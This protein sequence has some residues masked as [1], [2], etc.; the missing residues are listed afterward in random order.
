MKTLIHICC[1]PCALVFTQDFAGRGG[2]VCLFWDN[3][4]IHP[5]TEYKNRKAAAMDFAVLA[6]LKIETS[7]DEKYGLR[8]FL[9]AAGNGKNCHVCY[10][11]R[12]AA[13][14]KH[15]MTMGFAAFTTTLM[16]SPYQNFEAICDIGGKIAQK[17]GL[18]FVVEDFRDR[19]REGLA[20]ARGVGLYVQKYCG[21]I[22]SEEERYVKR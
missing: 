20:K 15:A 4:N 17:T 19:Y 14:A 18:V 7:D 11:T 13:T 21:C 22:F 5:F 1:G 6:G 8:G 16:A 10:H 12:L 3:F 9:E 2:D